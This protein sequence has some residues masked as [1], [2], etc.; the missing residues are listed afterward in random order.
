MST[1][2]QVGATSSLEIKVDTRLTFTN[3]LITSLASSPDPWITCRDGYYY[4]CA[5]VENELWVWKSETISG[6]DHSEKKKV[7]IP[8]STGPNSQEVW[9]PE[10]HFIGERWYIYYAASDGHN[11]N[12]RIY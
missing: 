8:P 12:H 7:W 3:P 10:L 6:L 1:P 9:A 2:D 11:A 5:S 4:F